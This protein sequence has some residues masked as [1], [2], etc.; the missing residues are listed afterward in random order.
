MEGKGTSM[1]LDDLI[2][3]ASTRADDLADG[4]LWSRTEWIEYANDAQNEACRRARLLVDS[5]TAAVCS[6]AMVANTPAY[7]LHDSIIFVRRVRLLDASGNALQYLGRRH[8]QDLDRD[9]GSGWEDE[10]G[11][12]SH[13]VPDID[14]HMLRVYP[15]PDAVFTAKLTVVRTPFV[16]SPNDTY[17]MEEGDDVPEIRGRWHLGLVNWMLARAY[18]KHDSD[19][20]NPKLALKF[21]EDF[22][23]EFGKKSSAIDEAWLE[24]ESD[25]TEAEGNF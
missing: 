13:W 15:T 8:A 18:N 10:T 4:Q 1:T 21:E 19:C 20:Y 7:A 3:I 16:T 12:P 14:T 24:R 9:V 23:R 5:T 6:V 17:P 2:T 25:Y 22:S 11:P